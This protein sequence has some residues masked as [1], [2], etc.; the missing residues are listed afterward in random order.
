MRRAHERVTVP[1]CGCVNVPIL[2]VAFSGSVSL[3]S[4]FID[5][6]VS[7]AV[8]TLSEFATGGLFV[9][10]TMMMHVRFSLRAIYG[11][12]VAELTEAGVA[13]AEPGALTT[14]TSILFS[15]S[16]FS[17]STSIRVPFVIVRSALPLIDI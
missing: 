10:F 5:T 8:V 6:E 3:P 16:G 1:F 11:V 12:R 4:T 13:N 15:P 9:G 7:K 2:S 17:S 14:T